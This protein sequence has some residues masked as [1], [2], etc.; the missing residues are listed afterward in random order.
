[1]KPPRLSTRVA[2]AQVNVGRLGV[3]TE[4]EFGIVP[5]RMLTRTVLSERVEDTVKSLAAVSAAYAAALAANASASDAQAIL[6]PLD[7]TQARAQRH[8]LVA[9][10][11]RGRCSELPLG[12]GEY[13]INTKHERT[14]DL[15]FRE[16]SQPLDPQGIACANTHHRRCQAASRGPHWRGSIVIASSKHHMCVKR[17]GQ[18][19]WGLLSALVVGGPLAQ[20]G[21]VRCGAHPASTALSSPHGPPHA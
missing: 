5:Q 7:M 15:S 6:G 3:I 11:G 21:V 8:R 17:A 19:P 20:L 9:G 13:L 4:L 2:C 14:C 16:S 10:S 1:V 12:R 18:M